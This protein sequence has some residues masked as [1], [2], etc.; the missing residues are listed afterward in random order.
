MDM[1]RPPVDGRPDADGRP[2][3]HWRLLPPRVSGSACQTL[4]LEGAQRRE[5]QRVLMIL[6]NKTIHVHGSQPT[7]LRHPVEFE[8]DGEQERSPCICPFRESPKFN[9]TP[10]QRPCRTRL[11]WAVTRALERR[12][13]NAR[14]PHLRRDTSSCVK[15]RPAFPSNEV[16]PGESVLNGEPTEGFED[17]QGTWLE[18]VQHHHRLVFST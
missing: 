3:E 6:P 4:L 7:P 1:E 16:Q 2:P 11:S 14:S 9:T 17:G 13:M 15:P 18:L 5:P 8:G 12:L 10:S